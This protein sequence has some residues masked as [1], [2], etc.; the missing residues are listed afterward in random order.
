MHEPSCT[1]SITRRRLDCT[2]LKHE[3]SSRLVLLPS[4]LPSFLRFIY[5]IA[6]FMKDAARVE[7]HAEALED[8]SMDA[9]TIAMPKPV[10]NDAQPIAAAMLQAG[11][12]PCAC[13]CVCVPV[14]LLPP[15]I[16]L[17]P[18]PFCDRRI[19]RELLMDRVLDRTHCIVVR[20]VDGPHTVSLT[21]YLW[22]DLERTTL[23][24]AYVPAP[25]HAQQRS[26]G[27]RHDST[28]NPS[29]KTKE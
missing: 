3:L 11:V 29:G 12:C 19:R 2:I 24:M 25:L 5:H 18:V 8:S 27:C 23:T 17:H 10:G 28:T 22:M 4:F 15:S 9:D 16:S 1:L 6:A 7:G 21:V 14:S 20:V 13:V 26:N